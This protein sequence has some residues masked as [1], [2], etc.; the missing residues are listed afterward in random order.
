MIFASESLDGPSFSLIVKLCEY[1]LTGVLLSRVLLAAPWLLVVALA[2]AGGDGGGQHGA[3]LDSQGAV[4]G[5]APGLG[6][7]QA[8]HG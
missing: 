4:A 3:S 6:R 7:V 2:D 8:D 5:Q 1:L